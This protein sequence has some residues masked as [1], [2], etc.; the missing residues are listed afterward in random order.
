[1]RWSYCCRRRSVEPLTRI[2]AAGPL[3]SS[4]SVLARPPENTNSPLIVLKPKP[5]WKK[6]LK[7]RLSRRGISARLI[8]PSTRPPPPGST[9]SSWPSPTSARRRPSKRARANAP[10]EPAQL[11]CSLPLISPSSTMPARPKAPSSSPR[12]RAEKSTSKRDRLR[13]SPARS[14]SPL[15]VSCMPRARVLKRSTCIPCA[16]GVVR[17][18]AWPSAMAPMRR[19]FTVKSSGGSAAGSCPGTSS[20][21]R[22]MASAPA[23]DGSGAGGFSGQCRRSKRPCTPCSSAE[24]MR[25]APSMAGPSSC[26]WVWSAWRCRRRRVSGNSEPSRSS[27]ATRR[28]TA[29]SPPAPSPLAANPIQPAASSVSLAPTTPRPSAGSG[30]SA[31]VPSWIRPVMVLSA[32]MRPRRR[33]SSPSVSAISPLPTGSGACSDSG[34]G[35]A[36]SLPSGA[37]SVMA[38]PTRSDCT[39]RRAGGAGAPAR[40]W[41]TSSESR[42]WLLPASQGLSQRSGSCRASSTCGGKRPSS[43][44]RAASDGLPVYPSPTNRLKRAGSPSNSTCRS[45]AAKPWSLNRVRPCTWVKAMPQRGSESAASARSIVPSMRRSPRRAA[46]GRS[47]CSATVAGPRMLALSRCSS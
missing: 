27:R 16:T 2:S 1:M 14:Q 22:A 23:A 11:P 13:P 15:A 47:S 8:R 17:S 4:R 41:G 6:S 5:F 24:G 29:R 19:S 32:P 25:T 20:S 7:S 30:A 38:V 35:V 12:L 45:S 34:C 18:S 40:A 3:I 36:A 21:A 39:S 26:T 33:I 43:V 37:G 28:S 44:A 10:G 42:H 9:S 31:P 46:S